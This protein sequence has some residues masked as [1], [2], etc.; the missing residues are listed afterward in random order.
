MALSFLVPV[1]LFELGTAVLVS[2]GWGLGVI[3]ALSY[4]IARAQ[5]AAPWWLSASTC[6][7]RWWWLY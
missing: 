6:S 4:V 2:L 1:L 5:G 7:S 3:A